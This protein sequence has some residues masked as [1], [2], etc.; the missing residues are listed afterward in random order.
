MLLEE[1][2]ILENSQTIN[3]VV[4]NAKCQ[5]LFEYHWIEMEIKNRKSV[6]SK[7]KQQKTVSSRIILLITYFIAMILSKQDIWINRSWF[8]KFLLV[9]AWLPPMYKSNNHVRNSREAN[10]MDMSSRPVLPNDTKPTKSNRKQ[11][12]LRL[13]SVR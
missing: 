10:C 13:L 11:G 1:H 7:K 4:E 2:R 8:R 12:V 6:K 3:V 9:S 5:G